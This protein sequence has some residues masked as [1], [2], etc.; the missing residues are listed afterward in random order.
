[1]SACRSKG[2]W[3]RAGKQRSERMIQ[4]LQRRYYSHPQST[5]GGQ[6]TLGLVFHRG[7]RH[8]PCVARE[9]P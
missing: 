2:T 4:N 7:V 3:E 1:M 9:M 5:L 6:L 8:T